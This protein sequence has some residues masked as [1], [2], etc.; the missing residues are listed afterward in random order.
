VS[1]NTIRPDDEY[2]NY[3]TTPYHDSQQVMGPQR[4]VVKRTHSFNSGCLKGD[5]LNVCA[6]EPVRK[7]SG[8]FGFFVYKGE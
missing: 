1:G 4:L 2:L 3:I 5:I 7:R 8:G 6:N